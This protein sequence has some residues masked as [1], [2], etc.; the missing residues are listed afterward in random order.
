MEGISGA[1]TGSMLELV[2][3]YRKHKKVFISTWEDSPMENCNFTRP[4]ARCLLIGLLA[5]ASL[6]CGAGPTEAP[7]AQLQ[8]QLIQPSAPAS[9]AP[10]V[11]QAAPA[12]TPVPAS[13]GPRPS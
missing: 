7:Q 12:A 13:P 4:D 2:I 10:R 5:A 11:A 1:T 3:T 9:Q 6:G 8:S